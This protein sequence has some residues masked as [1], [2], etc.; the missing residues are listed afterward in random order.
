MVDMRTI[1]ESISSRA[2]PLAL[3]PSR[4]GWGPADVAKLAKANG[5][6]CIAVELGDPGE[7][8]VLGGVRHDAGWFTFEWIEGKG[9]EGYRWQ[10]GP[11]FVAVP[12]LR[13]ETGTGKKPEGLGAVRYVLTSGVVGLS[14][15]KRWLVR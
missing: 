5:W 15:L 2:V 13:P 14:E 6:E 1:R 4:R 9:T 3:L 7:R 12:E 11:A 10:T 8:I